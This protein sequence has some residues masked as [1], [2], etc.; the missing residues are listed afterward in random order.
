MLL[1]RL[2]SLALSAWL[3]AGCATLEGPVLSPSELN[4]GAKEY[5][6]KEVTVRGYV[7]LSPAG[8]ILYE[9]KRMYKNFEHEWQGL[10][11]NINEYDKFCLTIANPVFIRDKY[12]KLSRRPVVVRGV[13]LEN[14][15]DENSIDIGACPLNTAIIVKDIRVN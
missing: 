11:E 14:Y 9:S 4:R 2:A 10:S 5:N 6:N 8:H 13:F 1:R 7:I 12:P 15:L 3:V